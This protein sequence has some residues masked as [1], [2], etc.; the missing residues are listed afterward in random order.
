MTEFSDVESIPYPEPSP[1]HAEYLQ[2]K[3]LPSNHVACD[4]NLIDT[5]Q[6]QENKTEN[7]KSVVE[8]DG[9]ISQPTEL[10]SQSSERGD[11]LKDVNLSFVLHESP[12]LSNVLKE[13]DIVLCQHEDGSSVQHT[14]VPV[15]AV[16]YAAPL[17]LGKVCSTSSPDLV[18]TL[19]KVDVT[20]EQ[21]QEGFSDDF[22]DV[23]TN[24]A[25][26]FDGSTAKEAAPLP[27][28]EPNSSS[29]PDSAGILNGV[30][31]N[32]CSQ[33]EDGTLREVLDAHIHRNVTDQSQQHVTKAQDMQTKTS[34][35][36]LFTKE[37]K[38]TI[39][40][41]GIVDT[42]PPFESV[43][44]AVTMFGGI[45]D[46]KAHKALTIE[47]RKHAHHELEK[48]QQDI[49]VYAEQW[50]AAELAKAESLKELNNTKVLV[51][52]LKVDLERA[53]NVEAQ[54][55]QD[56]ELAQLRA[57]EIEDGISDEASVAAK[58]FLEIAN[59]RNEA[60]SLDL[61]FVNVELEALQKHYDSLVG[62]RDV[63]MRRAEEAFSSLK[64]L[65]K[66]VEE[67]TL[68]LIT[69][70]ESLDFAHAAHLEAEEHRVGAALAKDHDYMNWEKELKQA[71]EEIQRL[72]KQVLHAKD[73]KAN[74]ETAS[75][76]LVDLKKELAAYME[77]KL[78]E[79][80]EESTEKEEP[81]NGQDDPKGF[82]LALVLKRKEFEE[83]NANIDKAKNE[84]SILRVAESSLKSDL[85]RE[86][87]DLASLRQR[88]GM[89]SITLS[90][91]ESEIA[92]KKQEIKQTIEKEKEARE[93]MVEL[94]KL[95]QQAAM[96]ADH[97]KSSI[98]MAR[99]ELRKVDEE[100]EQVRASLSTTEIRLQASLKEIEACRASEILAL[101]AVKALQESDEAAAMGESPRG[102]P[103]PLEE[104]YILSKRAHEA[105]DLAN[106]KLSSAIVQ[107]EVAKESE[108]KSLQRV[109]EAYREMERR[110]EALKIATKKAE[111]AKEGKLGVEQE[112]RKWRA[113]HE[114][115][116]RATDAANLPSTPAKNFDDGSRDTKT[117]GQETVASASDVVHP[118]PEAKIYMS[119]NKTEHATPE[120]KL[121]KK[122][123][124]FPR[125]VM[126]LVNKKSQSRK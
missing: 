81:S 113:E 53:Q 8:K 29:S 6:Q 41:R 35:S 57:K 38:E 110:K 62:E 123:S 105:E 103:L 68:E 37:L 99:E 55:K 109:E 42:T 59:S 84:V 82:Q 17:S 119:V 20:P 18:K 114:Q 122:K 71:E 50:E 33:I 66:L 79:Q 56:A 32:I 44:E 9:C 4:E 92:R 7:F 54:A 125:I 111:K 28:E 97:W 96:E 67:L 48:A 78:K 31:G 115:R 88:E 36:A 49:L 93:K 91:L 120:F 46:W 13:Q 100:A 117:H 76:L 27:H 43:K 25:Q 74:L 52:E 85:E 104:Y 47:K 63:A 40:N 3:P 2:F 65:E 26:I 11:V 60:A 16:M 108:S 80:L 126:F 21:L 61:K 70:K 5:Q 64:E 34:E 12:D 101:A 51:E 69:T 98:K 90:S 87:A 19:E 75:T 86:K 124:F 10:S 1:F 77:S 39:A 106:E 107:I 30:Q 83:V 89:A 121:R 118:N 72:K 15:S 116:R 95:L 94:P 23:Q 112:L 22:A 45:V 24:R 73:I 58:A 102:V 14:V